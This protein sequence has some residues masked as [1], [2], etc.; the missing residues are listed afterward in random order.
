MVDVARPCWITQTA[1][2]SGLS[3]SAAHISCPYG[4]SDGTGRHWP[5]DCVEKR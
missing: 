2:S 4:A 5:P 1:G 3:T